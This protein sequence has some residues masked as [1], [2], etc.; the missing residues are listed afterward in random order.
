MLCGHGPH[1]LRGIEIC[2]GKPLLYSL[3]NFCFMDNSQQVV[4]RDEWEEA[5]WAAAE[6]LAGPKGITQPE[7]ST[8]A[9]FMEWKHVIGI[10]SDPIWFESVVAECR[11]RADGALKRMH[12]HPIELGF[13]GRD[14]DCGIPRLA[15]D[16]DA[17]R[18]QA[19]RILERLQAVSAGFGTR[20]EIETIDSP[21]GRSSVGHVVLE[22]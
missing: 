18:N 3:G 20:I 5:E 2:R 7:S 22:G 6:A 15:F 13:E 21:R 1:Q 11:F 10:F 12:L 19:R 9:E 17:N 14:A 8:P 4:A 16:T